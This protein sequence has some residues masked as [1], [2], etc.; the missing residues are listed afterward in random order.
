MVVRVVYDYALL[1]FK[2]MFVFLQ[3]FTIEIVKDTDETCDSRR[4]R[5]KAGSLAD[6]VRPGRLCDPTTIWSSTDTNLATSTQCR[7]QQCAL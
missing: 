2:I 1:D 6:R 5:E 3:K 7:A 4:R